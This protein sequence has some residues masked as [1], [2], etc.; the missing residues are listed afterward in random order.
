[1]NNNSD[2]KRFPSSKYTDFNRNFIDEVLKIVD[3]NTA[4]SRPEPN[5]KMAK[6]LHGDELEVVMTRENGS[7]ITFYFDQYNND[8]VLKEVRGKTSSLEL[9]IT[10]Q[11]VS[12]HLYAKVDNK[13]VIKWQI[14]DDGSGKLYLDGT[15]Y[16][17]SH[18]S[19]KTESRVIS[20]YSVWGPSNVRVQ[21]SYLR[22]S[23]GNDV[24]TVSGV[25]Q[26]LS[27]D[28]VPKVREFSE[29]AKVTCCV[30][31]KVVSEQN[32]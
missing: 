23:N 32:K 8:W 31:R 21:G 14:Y 2:L 16:E 6:Y 9:E 17:N 29:Q 24:K 7:K 28:I 5:P 18:Y 22:S 13:I 26:T 1:M 19:S 10:S 27:D 12:Y 3:E 20:N 25:V 11:V 4:G 30:S 15:V